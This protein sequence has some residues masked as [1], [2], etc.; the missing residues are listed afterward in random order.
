[1]TLEQINALLDQ[2]DAGKAQLDRLKELGVEHLKDFD[3]VSKSQFYA[4]CLSN[5]LTSVWRGSMAL[6]PDTEGWS[7]EGLAR[8]FTAMKRAHRQVIADNPKVIEAAKRAGEKET[9]ERVEAAKAGEGPSGSRTT[10][11][12]GDPAPANPGA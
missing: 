3:K 2:R 6:D 9:A 8:N 4:E 1:M 7:D 5:N 12:S 11:D 10:T